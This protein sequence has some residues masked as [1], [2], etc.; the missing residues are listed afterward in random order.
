M[1]IN[2]KLIHLSTILP[3]IINISLCMA[4]CYNGEYE[5]NGQCC[6]MC[7]AGKRVY[8]HCDEF[9]RTTCIPCTEDT[10]TDSF[11][12]LRECLQCSVC[13]LNNGLRV[14]KACTVTSN[15]LCEPLPGHYCINVKG[16]SCLKAEKHSTCSPGQYINQTGTEFRDTEC[17]PC[18]AGSYSDGTLCKLHTNCETLRQITIK[19][20]TEK[21]DAECSNDGQSYKLPLI[22]SFCGV[23]VLAVIVV[24]VVIIVKKKSYRPAAQDL[25]VS[26]L[27]AINQN[28]VIK[29]H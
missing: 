13:D 12:R 27:R 6:P 17:A 14:K 18:P 26:Y 1:W 9:T 21:D 23:C 29:I 20:G 2:C 22:L 16:K 28:H 3:L 10:Y 5:I 4:T 7:D 8:W 25:S 19:P 11:N 15:T 24:I